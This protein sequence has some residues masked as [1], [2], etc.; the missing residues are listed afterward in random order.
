MKNSWIQDSITNTLYLALREALTKRVSPEVVA[1][2][3]EIFLEVMRYSNGQQRFHV[4]QAVRYLDTIIGF[5]APN[6]PLAR[7]LRTI[8]QRTSNAAAIQAWCAELER[9]WQG[10]VH[11]L[12]RVRNSVAH[13]GP[14]TEQ[15]VL[16]TQPFSQKVAV[17]ALWESIEGFIQGKSLAQS[18][19]DLRIQWDQWRSSLQYATSADH[20]FMTE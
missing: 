10:S 8:K 6:L 3:R 20:I 2:Q 18:H 15:A 9:V 5:V 12:E 4:G 7:D 16:I 1:V 14:F 19:A 11:R 17:W 13:G